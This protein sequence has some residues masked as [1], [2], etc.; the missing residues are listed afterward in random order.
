MRVQSLA[1]LAPVARVAFLGLEAVLRRETVFRAFETYR[2]PMDQNLVFHKGT[3]KVRAMESAH[4]FG[5]A[6]D[7]VPFI[8]HVWTWDVP[9]ASWDLLHRHA[10]S[11]GLLAPIAWDPGHIEHP[12]WSRSVRA[13]TRPPAL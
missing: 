5:L 10:R 7:F 12:A 9:K 4:Q 1:Y 3:S 11:V 8:G 2:S 13:S 6:V